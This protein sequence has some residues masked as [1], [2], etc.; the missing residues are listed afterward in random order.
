MGLTF[1]DSPHGFTGKLSVNTVGRHPNTPARPLP[2]LAGSSF[3][4]SKCRLANPSPGRSRK[5]GQVK[6]NGALIWKGMQRI[7]ENRV[8]RNFIEK[9]RGERVSGWLWVRHGLREWG[10]LSNAYLH[11]VYFS[12]LRLWTRGLTLTGT[13]FTGKCRSSIYLWER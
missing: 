11:A 13:A 4:E 1:W 10:P 6:E 7:E 8:G 5:R 9:P 12:F 3:T 2:H